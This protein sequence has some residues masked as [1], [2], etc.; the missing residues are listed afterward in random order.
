MKQVLWLT[1]GRLKF[2]LIALPLLFATIYMFV[3]ARDRYVSESIV[4]V[5][6]ASSQDQGS[7]PGV[8]MLLGGV[9]PPS[10]DDTLYLR[11]YIFSLD[12]LKRLESRLKLRDHFSSETSDVFYRLKANAD[13]EKF[14]D[15]YR[16][17]VEVIYDDSASLLTI[18][19]QGFDPAFAQRLNQ[20]I[21]EDSETFVNAFS[22]RMARQQMAFGEQELARASAKLQVEKLKVLDFQTR[23]KVID[24][25]AQMQAAGTLTAELQG[26]LARQEAE[27]RTARTYLNDSSYQIRAQMGQLEATRAQLALERQRATA[28]GPAGDRLNAQAAEYQDLLLQA[29]FAQDSYRIS[30]AAVENARIEASRKLK[31]L[32]IIEPPSLP[33]T[34]EYPKRIYNLVTLL[35]LS[36]LL[37]GIA[38]LIT[39]TIREHI[40]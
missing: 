23:N 20:A 29:G 3:I 25:M 2:V 15:Y 38:R 14:L 10:H 16:S 27:L 30:L 36:L 28:D 11:S 4:T 9:N 21:L 19:V 24:P 13:Q 12:L 1:P 6:Q 40:D 7:M 32:V 8:A 34:A 17:R 33:E 37:Y 39:A 18:R 5:R 35:V 31:S 26:A 22:Q